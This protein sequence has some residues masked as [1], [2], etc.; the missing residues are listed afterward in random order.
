MTP[1]LEGM[2]RLVGL[3]LA[4]AERHGWRLAARR[5][6]SKNNLWADMGSRGHAAEVEEQARRL[7]LRVERLEAVW[8]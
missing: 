7:G 8:G 1:S 6:S 4:T 5:I 2:Q 3:R